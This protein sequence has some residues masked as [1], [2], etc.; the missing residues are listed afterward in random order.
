MPSAHDTAA[1]LRAGVAIAGAAGRPKGALDPVGVHASGPSPSPPASQ[2]P[3]APLGRAG[4]ISSPAAPPTACEVP[5]PLRAGVPAAAWGV[6][7]GRVPVGLPVGGRG[8]GRALSIHSGGGV[9]SP[10][11]SGLLPTPEPPRGVASADGAAL[12]TGGLVG[13][14]GRPGLSPPSLRF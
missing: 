2:P 3:L 10:L 5:L 9:P 8:A 14:L 4:V 7:A 11:L 1:A 13:K 12:S 6:A